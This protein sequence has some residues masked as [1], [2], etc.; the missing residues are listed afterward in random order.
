M[1]RSIT[2]IYDTMI[3]EKEMMVQLN[4]LQPNIDNAQTLLT[5]LTSASKVAVW[6]LMLF[7]MAVSIWMVE[8]LFDEH[9]A[10]IN[11]REKELIVGSQDWIAKRVLEF[12]YGDTL[13]WL[14]D[15]YQYATVD[16]ALQIIDLVSVNESNGQ[17]FIKVAKLVG[18][19][20]TELDVTELASFSSYVQKIKIAGIIYNSLSRPADNLKI[21]Y[22]VYINPLVMN[23][24]GELL[25]N[26]SIK[27]VELAI[28]NY[29]KG[30]PFNG[31]FNITQLTDLIQN[32]EG[33]I[34]P[35]FDSAEAS[36]GLSPYSPIV[37]NYI[38]NAGYLKVDIGFPLSSTITYIYQS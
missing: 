1:A 36:Y 3:S 35:V 28:T 18:G 26:P 7:V 31:V 4:E 37:D 30:L 9:K 21:Y 23:L 25:S 2:Q 20:P 17:V 34:D 11:Q 16:P 27:P 32:S 10:W 5:D 15:K 13:V 12:Q 22:H 38:S 29:C 19:V 24:N 14:N 6:R 8:K 33:V